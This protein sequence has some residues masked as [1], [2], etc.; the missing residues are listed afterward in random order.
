MFVMFSGKSD[1][2]L[3]NCGKGLA[4]P[5]NVMLETKIIPAAT[6]FFMFPPNR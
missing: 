5:T 3:P 4:H 6:N 2:T 1:A